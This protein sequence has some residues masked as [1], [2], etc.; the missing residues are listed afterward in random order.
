M[1]LFEIIFKNLR[2]ISVLVGIHM[3]SHGREYK[4]LKIHFFLRLQ[5]GQYLRE[6]GKFK[7]SNGNS[8]V[9]KKKRFEVQLCT[10]C[11]IKRD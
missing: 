3:Y 10:V 11:L 8:A 1:E 4:F 7:N 9:I 6:N 5:E 2:E